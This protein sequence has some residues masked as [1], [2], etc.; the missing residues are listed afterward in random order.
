MD[1][2]A[3]DLAGRGVTE[4]AWQR[5]PWLR[6]LPRR[7]PQDVFGAA[8]RLVLVSPHPDDEVLGCGGLLHDAGRRALPVLIVAV[9]DG[10]ACYPGHPVWTQER[11]RAARRVELA[12]AL[13]ELRMPDLTLAELHLPDSQVAATHQR[14]VDALTALLRP[15][16]LLLVTWRRDGHGDHEACARA[17]LAAA[18]KHDLAVT[19]FPIWAWHW[20]DPLH[21]PPAGVDAFAYGLDAAAHEAKARALCH[22]RSQRPHAEL[23][24]TA[25]ILP[26]HITARF[27]RDFEVLFDT[28][29]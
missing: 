17:T 15:G 23:G 28:R 7:S 19:E 24:D 26:D 29:D 10:E 27:Q 14:L 4:E 16:D 11:L 9:T 25:P 18:Q 6:D 21:G 1:A 13:A 12:A 2:V 22:F 3:P 8:R 20:L 5:S